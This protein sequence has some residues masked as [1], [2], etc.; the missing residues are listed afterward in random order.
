LIQSLA[1]KSLEIEQITNETGLCKAGVEDSHLIV[2]V[3]QVRN[4]VI[5]ALSELSSK[6]VF[7]S[8]LLRE[9]FNELVKIFTSING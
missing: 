5:A 8:Q 7:V 3:L 2:H 4:K 9:F 1:I 6:P